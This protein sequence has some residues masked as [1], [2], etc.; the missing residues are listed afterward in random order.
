[1][2]CVKFPCFEYVALMAPDHLKGYGELWERGGVTG[3]SKSSRKE[4]YGA[5][6]GALEE[7]WP[8]AM[9]RLKRGFRM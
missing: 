4:R 7:I 5:A 1:M 6:G 2:W 8:E 3:L 9:R